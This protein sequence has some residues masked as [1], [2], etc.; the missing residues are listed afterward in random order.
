[1]RCG[2]RDLA[3]WTERNGRPLAEFIGGAPVSC[4]AQGTD[5]YGRT[6]ATC[7]A[8]GKDIEAWMVLNGWALAQPHHKL[9]LMA[10]SGHCGTE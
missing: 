5:R 4:R 8:Q 1:M 6:I 10:I 3:L 2:R 7:T 9:L